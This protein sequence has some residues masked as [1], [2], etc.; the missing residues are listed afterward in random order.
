[1]KTP[2]ILEHLRRRIVSGEFPPGSKLPNRPEL[3]AEYSVSVSAFQKCINQLIEWNFLESRGMK[4]IRV[5]ANPPHLSRYALVFPTLPDHNE[6]PDDTLYRSVKYELPAF[7]AEHPEIYFTEAFGTTVFYTI[8]LPAGK[9]EITLFAAET[10]PGNAQK[11]RTFQ[12][13]VN[14]H[15]KIFDLY[16]MTPGFLH[17]ARHSWNVKV[18]ED[19]PVVVKLTGECGLNGILIRKKG[20]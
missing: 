2:E 8:P 19:E 18:R 5:T 7:Q 15:K 20:D 10:Y 12:A 1:M 6:L 16:Q 13:E 9:Y 14:K 17:E 4:G 11:G 3:L